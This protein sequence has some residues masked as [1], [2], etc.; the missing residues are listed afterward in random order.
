MAEGILRSLDANLD[1]QSAGTRPAAEVHPAAIQALGEI[2]I[3]IGGN[4]PKSVN[5]FLGEAFDYVITVCDDAAETC[6]T[7]SGSVAHRLHFSIEDP[8]AAAG[9]REEV[10][11]TFRRIRDEIR[12]RLERFHREE[13]AAPERA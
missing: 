12:N 10:L 9:T 13:L 4:R 1:V 8:A 3:D 5:Q 6:P 2:G 7:F 11:A